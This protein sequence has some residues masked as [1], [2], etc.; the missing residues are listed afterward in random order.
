MVA[1][2]SFHCAT[3]SAQTLWA[4]GLS[5]DSA[6]HELC[7]GRTC[8]PTQAPVLSFHFSCSRYLITNPWH[9]QLST[10]LTWR[11]QMDHIT[12][13]H[14][15]CPGT[16]ELVRDLNHVSGPGLFLTLQEENQSW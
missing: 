3:R 7:A 8:L 10:G 15:E 13:A 16:V 5:M 11:S 6:L 14:I 9:I 12:L 1:P 2:G 4:Q